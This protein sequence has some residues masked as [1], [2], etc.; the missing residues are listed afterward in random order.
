MNAHNRGV[1]VRVLTN[2]CGQR[3]VTPGSF[4]PQAFL[5]VLGVDIRCYH[6]TSLLHGKYM[7]VDDEVSI[8]SVNWGRGSETMN[9]E[10]GFNVRGPGMAPLRDFYGA[11]FD[12]DFGLATPW[13]I[14]QH[15][16]DAQLKIV[17]DPTPIAVA[18]WKPHPYSAC[19]EPTVPRHNWHSVTAKTV[20]LISNPDFGALPVPVLR[21]C[22]D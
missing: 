12:E 6:R 17:R 1:K 7:R 9:R 8:S 22:C 15:Y 11:V 21:V 14:T 5:R 19:P 16:S 4:T 20:T 3:P 2:D 18:A 13:P 10:A